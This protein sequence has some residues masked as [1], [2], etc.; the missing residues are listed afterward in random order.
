MIRTTLLT[1]V[2]FASTIAA[3]PPGGGTVGQPQQPPPPPAAPP[4]APMPAQTGAPAVT[5]SPDPAMLAQAKN[6]FAELQSGKLDRTTLTTEMS[7]ALTDDKLATVKSSI[8]TL[9]APVSFEQEHAGTQSGVRYG[10][11]LVTFSNGAKLDF[12][13]GLD[14]QGKIAGMRLTPMQ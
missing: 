2:L 14:G 5:P 13:I 4:A 1:L 10:V 6:V 9:G 8:G 12:L 3:V 7:A 11:Y